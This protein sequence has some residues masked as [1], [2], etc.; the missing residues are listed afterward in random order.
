MTAALRERPRADVGRGTIASHRAAPSARPRSRQTTAG[1]SRPK[2]KVLNQQAIRRRARRRNALLTLFV[3]VLLGFFAV[4]F[5]QAQLVADQQDLDVLRARIAEAEAEHARI[6]RDVEI[7]SSPAVIFDRATNNL[8][9]VRA[10]QPVYLE[11]VAP[12][13]DIPQAPVFDPAAPQGFMLAAPQAASARI[14][15]GIS[16]SGSVASDE[17]AAAGQASAS[18]A[19]PAVSTDGGAKPTA[20]S[21]NAPATSARVAVAPR[22]DTAAQDGSASVGDGVA[23]AERTSGRSSFSGVAVAVGSGVAV[24]QAV[25]PPPSGGA[26]GQANEASGSA[27]LAGTRAVTGGPDSG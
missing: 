2:L 23:V 12:V 27:S 22:A 3:F 17:T 6:A 25:I 9:M 21:A 26:G 5:I 19:A 20:T 14:T 13:R 1:R 11:A 24:D 16:G 18:P 10:H 4:A 7:A 8:G 15:A